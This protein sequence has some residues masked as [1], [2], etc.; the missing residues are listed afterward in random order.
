M[1]NLV[2]FSRLVATV[3]AIGIFGATALPTASRIGM[4]AEA[5]WFS[6]ASV[7]WPELC[8]DHGAILR[9]Y[10]EWTRTGQRRALWP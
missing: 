1:R 10:F 6:E 8:F 2:R 9:D 4:A 5:G 3:A 7:P